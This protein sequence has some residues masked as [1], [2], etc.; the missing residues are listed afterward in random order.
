MTSG[1]TSLPWQPTTAKTSLLSPSH[2]HTHGHTRRQ[3]DH[4]LCLFFARK[5][6]IVCQ[7]NGPTIPVCVI[8]NA[9][10]N[11]RLIQCRVIIITIIIV[12]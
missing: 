10:V 6:L 1:P 12:T 11:A 4:L 9:W 8:I 7:R 5:I 2:D 3:P